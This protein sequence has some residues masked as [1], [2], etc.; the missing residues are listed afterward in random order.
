MRIVF[1]G[2]PAF[3]LPTL[4]RLIESQHQVVA[5]VTQP[6][7][8]AGR[9]RALRPP[10]AKELALGHDVPVLQPERVNAPDA[11]NELRAHAPDAIVI[12]AYGQILK[13]PLLDLPRRGCLN[14]HAS[15]LPAYRGAAPV[16]G[17]LLAGEAKTG[18]T[19]LE[20]VLDLDA[21]PMLAQRSVPI[22]RHDTTGSLTEKLAMVGADLLIETLPPWE[23]GEVAPQPQDEA[24]VS[25]VPSL[26]RK[27]AVIDWSLPA[28]EIWRGVRA[29]NPWPVATTTLDGDALRILE[30]EPL[31][32]ES[33]SEPGT[34]L[35][36]PDGTDVPAGSGF[37]V[38]CGTG[39]L[40]VVR[41]QRSGRREL[42]GEE[43]L[44]GA[45][46]LLG[47]RLG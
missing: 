11:L 23:R 46:G 14:V 41:A 29:Y 7:R 47:K 33:A 21:G 10:A 2:S 36:L 40:A 5:V 18:V 20:V 4:R 15:L 38:S 42:S 16:A 24:L 28:V 35:A 32:V 22:E 8:P 19:I 27:D 12:A 45:P 37:A 44:R 39:L 13:Q 34:T 31:E 1:M 43:L 9:R 30:V 25:Y 3:A 6:D 17:A 26:R